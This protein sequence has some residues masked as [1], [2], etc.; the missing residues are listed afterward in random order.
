MHVRSRHEPLI[1][2]FTH[3]LVS[4]L[5]ITYVLNTFP[6]K[7]LTYFCLNQL[8]SMYVLN[9]RWSSA[10]WIGTLRKFWSFKE[11]KLV[12][13]EIA[14]IRTKSSS[15]YYTF[16]IGRKCS[17]KKCTDLSAMNSDVEYFYLNIF[18]IFYV[19]GE[20]CNF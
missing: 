14:L 11:K 17:E 2:R 3:V 13:R 20:L 16:E 1:R 18:S 6:P 7:G 4:I 8:L 15:L 5:N 12:F 19:F 10:V 9:C